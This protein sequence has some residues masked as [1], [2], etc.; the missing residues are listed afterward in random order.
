MFL[1]VHALRWSSLR[2]LDWY[3]TLFCVYIIWLYVQARDIELTDY[4]RSTNSDALPLKW[5]APE[6]IRDKMYT[7]KTDVWSFG[8]LAWEVFS[9]GKTPYGYM[10]G[11]D[12]AQAVSAGQRLEKPISATD[13]MLV[14]ILL[15]YLIFYFYTNCNRCS[16]G[17]IKSCWA[18]DPLN[19]PSFAILLATIQSYISGRASSIPKGATLK[20]SRVTDDDDDEEET[21]L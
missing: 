1:W 4:Y 13:Q 17:I 21:A 8:V 14:N 15:M 9:Y 10:T 19:R 3:H 6:S 16:Y 2:T 12:I 20:L 11:I 18:L 5:M 7:S